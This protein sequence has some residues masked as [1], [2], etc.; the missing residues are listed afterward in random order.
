MQFLPGHSYDIGSAAGWGWIPYFAD[1]A[2]YGSAP[3]GTDDHTA[4]F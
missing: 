3:Y 1:G 4:N 2:K